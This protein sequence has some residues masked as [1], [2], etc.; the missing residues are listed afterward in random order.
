MTKK[1]LLQ[2]TIDYYSEDVN[3]RCEVDGDC[4]YSPQKAGKA[5]I[6]KGCA[7]GRFMT[8]AQQKEADAQ[9][10]PSVASLAKNL[11]PKS[12]RSF[13]VEFLKSIQHL[14]DIGRFWDEKGLSAEGIERAKRIEIKFGLV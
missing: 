5:D 13:D 2:S 9:A 8:K 1:E 14:H 6:S 12:L 10:M 4:S 11:I 7:I 3:R